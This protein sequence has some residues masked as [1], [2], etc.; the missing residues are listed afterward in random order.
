MNIGFAFQWHMH[1]RIYKQE[2]TNL[3][4]QEIQN[5]QFIV[6][7]NYKNAAIDPGAR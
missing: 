6:E 4:S 1:K 5:N 7:T 2:E 3:N